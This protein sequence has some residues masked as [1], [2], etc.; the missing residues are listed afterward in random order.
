MLSE[1]AFRLTAD[2]AARLLV[3]WQQAGTRGSLSKEIFRCE[4]LFDE[5]HD[6]GEELPHAPLVRVAAEGR[7][8]AEGWTWAQ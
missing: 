1:R 5:I 6:H 2:M 3:A 7:T 8:R 4:G